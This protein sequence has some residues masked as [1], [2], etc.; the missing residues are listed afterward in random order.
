MAVVRLSDVVIP[1]V[2]L[3]YQALNTPELTA[4]WQAG[5]VVRTELMDTIARTGGKQVTLPFWKDLDSSIEPNM[6]NDDPTDLAVPNKVGTGIMTARKA[7]MNQGYSSMDLIGELSGSEP[8]QHIRN[9]FGT[10]WARQYQRRLIAS[11]KGILADNI[12]N[13]GGDMVVNISA[14]AGELA[15]F[16]STAAIDAAATMGDALDANGFGAIAVHSAIRTKMVKDQDIIYIADAEGK[17]TIQTYKG[18]RVIVDDALV[19][20]GAAGPDRLYMSVLIGTGFFGFG[21]EIGSCFAAGEGVP[22]T[23]VEVDRT[24]A[25]GNGG[26]METIWERKTTIL[27]PYG[28]SWT[29]PTGADALTEFSPV[30]TDLAKAAPWNR[31]VDRKQAPIAFVISKA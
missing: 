4:F 18:M 17:L 19:Y 21:S 14:Q 30:L 31:V 26:G 5:L 15:R 27:H 22:M 29:D 25:A 7:F 23:P 11:L 12:A 24:P 8:L 6:S 10:Y 2:Y 28:W 3:G 13:D 9:R 20:S 16:N 1:E